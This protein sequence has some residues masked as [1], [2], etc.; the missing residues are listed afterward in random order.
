[1]EIN[2]EFIMENALLCVCNQKDMAKKMK[3]QDGIHKRL[4]NTD[5][6]LYVR[7]LVNKSDAS[8]DMGIA[9]FVLTREHCEAY[10]ILEEDAFAAATKNQEYTFRSMDEVMEEMAGIPMPHTDMFV[11]SNKLAWN[12]ASGMIHKEFLDR[13]MQEFECKAVYIL[14]SSIHECLVVPAS[15]G[16]S[17]EMDD[18]VNGVNEEV[19]QDSE[20]LSDHSYFY[21]GELHNFKDEVGSLVDF[22]FG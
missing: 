12:G 16:T 18:M 21:D 15:V 19:L 6:E 8:G 11:I 1:M 14:P 13:A 20:W 9:S 3:G 10:G 4:G 17:C 7:V 5:L 22:L 2:K